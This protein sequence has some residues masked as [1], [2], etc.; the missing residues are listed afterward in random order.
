MINNADE[1]YYCHI[2]NGNVA[3]SLTSS[4]EWSCVV[5]S[6]TFVERLGQ[7]IES[8]LTIT[9]SD[10]TTSDT[11]SNSSSNTSSNR[12]PLN[13]RNAGAQPSPSP[14]L[15]HFAT[16]LQRRADIHPMR[17]QRVERVRPSERESPL[18]RRELMDILN[19]S[20]NN[21]TNTT[22][23][24]PNITTNAPDNEHGSL[25]V[26]QVSAPQELEA[27]TSLLLASMQS[28]AHN[29][30]PTN[31]PIPLFH[32]FPR[33]PA[34]GGNDHHH[35]HHHHH[36]AFREFAEGI[37]GN[38]G[39]FAGSMNSISF[40]DILHHILMHES[41]H[42]GRPPASEALLDSLC[43]IVVTD[44]NVNDMGECNI[45]LEQFEVGDV[46]VKLTCGHTYKEDSIIH[47]LKMH[48]VC[49]SCRCVPSDESIKQND[50]DDDDDDDNDDDDSH[51]VPPLCGSDSDSSA[52][53]LRSTIS[54]SSESDSD[55][56]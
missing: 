37:V 21:T 25:L 53:I 13:N 42:A 47:W 11:S 51:S 4:Q 39:T 27:I 23:N 20:I 49:P 55:S 44:D 7:D 19:S 1:Q 22:T 26:R 30:L 31:R 17:M 15:S 28:Q 35:H 14:S 10:I 5:C 54:D 45:T 6:S 3:T 52:P 29:Q 43:R 56:D 32:N 50:D 34:F 41:S 40:D 12:S 2:C 48:N 24:T 36:H 9:T 33:N 38:I 18:F 8:F 46:A 16:R